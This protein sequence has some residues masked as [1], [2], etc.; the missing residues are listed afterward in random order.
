MKLYINK[1][2][3]NWV[4]DRFVSEWNNLNFQTSSNYFGN[5]IIWLIAPWT[6]NKIPRLILN[7]KKK[8]FAQY[9]ILMKISSTKKQS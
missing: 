3:E 6:W 9:I 4:V 5:K 1:P 7:R 8:F 2:G